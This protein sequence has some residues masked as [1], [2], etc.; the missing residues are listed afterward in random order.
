[1]EIDGDALGKRVRCPSCREV[2]VAQLPRAEVLDDDVI[3]T[4]RVLDEPETPAAPD[5]SEPADLRDLASAVGGEPAGDRP[6]GGAPVPGRRPVRQAP[7]GKKITHCPHCDKYF[8]VKPEMIGRK[9]RCSC[10]EV[11][12]LKQHKDPGAKPPRGAEAGGKTKPAAPGAGA[13][14]GKKPS[15]P[16]AKGKGPDGA[17]AVAAAIE[18]PEP[19]HTQSAAHR[20]PAELLRAQREARAR[21]MRTMIIIS[22]LVLVAIG[23]VAGYF[24][25]VHASAEPAEKPQPA[26]GTPEPT[27]NVSAELAPLNAALAEADAAVTAAREKLSEVHNAVSDLAGYLSLADQ[28]RLAAVP[29]YL[30]AD[31][32]VPFIRRRQRQLLDRVEV[33]YAK[34]EPAMLVPAANPAAGRENEVLIGALIGALED[35][36][37]ALPPEA[38][39]DDPPQVRSLT[40]L[41]ADLERLGDPGA[42]LA[43]W[44]AARERFPEIYPSLGDPVG[45]AAEAVE[46]ALKQ[47]GAAGA[48]AAVEKALKQTG[49][50]GVAADTEGLARARE[51]RKAVNDATADRAYIAELSAFDAPPG[52]GELSAALMNAS[53]RSRLSGKVRDLLSEGWQAFENDELRLA[54]RSYAQ[55]RAAVLG[56]PPELKETLGWDAAVVSASDGVAAAWRDRLR[57]RIAARSKAAQDPPS[58]DDDDDE[59]DEPAG[60]KVAWEPTGWEDATARLKALAEETGEPNLLLSTSQIALR[61]QID[62]RPAFIAFG[63]GPEVDGKD[64]PEYVA[65]RER[66]FGE[67]RK[68]VAG[69]DEVAAKPVVTTYHRD[70]TRYDRI[71]AAKQRHKL[72]AAALVTVQEGRGVVYWYVGPLDGFGEFVDH[73]GN[74]KVLRE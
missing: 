56:F 57:K 1:M 11:I 70:G 31:P 5:A 8:L 9:A 19:E 54:M 45:A 65:Y 36:P 17:A 2:F 25:Y 41:R 3:V 52:Y 20:D 62:A 7:S 24:L 4:G 15:S 49:A 10:G 12:T 30:D 48:A 53:R 33:G 23:G 18:K 29:E 34:Y 50:A 35:L 72:M 71:T 40:E 58:G 68:A 42:L 38:S 39:D 44:K 66:V 14:A 28:A 73:L 63:A 59:D 69:D 55:A 32:Q 51:M 47:A 60:P 26:T 21:S 67:F 6:S 74:A 27:V 46:K 61:K 64:D 22:V 16:K 43:D 37:A 13:A